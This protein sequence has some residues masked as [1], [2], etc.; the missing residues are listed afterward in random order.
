MT[1]EIIR[2]PVLQQMIDKGLKFFA[3]DA[4]GIA[5]ETGMGRRIN[6]IM[7]VCFFV[8]LQVRRTVSMRPSQQNVCS[9]CDAGAIKNFSASTNTTFVCTM[10]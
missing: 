7:Q 6:T 4:Y 10:D 5:Q 3:I 8:Q 9:P 1:K 2:H